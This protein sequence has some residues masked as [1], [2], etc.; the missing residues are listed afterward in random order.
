M[1]TRRIGSTWG[2]EKVQIQQVLTRFDGAEIQD[3]N[4]VH[5]SIFQSNVQ[6]I[7]IL[8]ISIGK[9]LVLNKKQETQD[10]L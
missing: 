3:R 9:F 2:G 7:P 8:N 6:F 1:A 5:L 4:D 10:L